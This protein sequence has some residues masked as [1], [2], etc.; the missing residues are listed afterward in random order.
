MEVTAALKACPLFKDFTDVGIQIFAAIGVPRA[1]PKGSTLF[2]ENR[3]GESLFIIGDGTVRLSARNTAGE[4]V[5]L[6]EVGAG[7]SM[8]ELALLQKSDRLCTATAMTDVT[9]VEIRHAD[10]QKLTA[11]KPQACMKLLMGI[12]TH[13]SQKVRDNR[14]AMKSLVGK[15]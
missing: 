8:G 3:P 15:T 12:V 4:D 9:A 2:V 5:S 6:G 14:D 10:F 13:F 1:F 7:E 11:A